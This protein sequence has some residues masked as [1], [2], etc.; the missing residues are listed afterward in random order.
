MRFSSDC[1]K[2]VE[3]HLIAIEI[4][5][6]KESNFFCYFIFG[7]FFPCRFHATSSSTTCCT[8]T[9]YPTSSTNM[10]V[11]Y[12]KN[13]L[14]VPFVAQWVKDLVLPQLWCRSQ[15]WLEFS[16]WPRNFHML[17]VWPKKKRMFSL[18]M[19]VLI[20]RVGSHSCDVLLIFLF[21]EYSDKCIFLLNDF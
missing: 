15:L 14:G 20:V 18:L 12:L 1:F 13:F 7:L 16:P 19:V 3:F 21:S 17:P 9:Y 10:W 6:L 2:T 5:D 11:F 4:F 8:T